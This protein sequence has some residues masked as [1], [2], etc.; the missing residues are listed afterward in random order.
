MRR[1]ANMIPTANEPGYDTWPPGSHE[2]GGA[3]PWITGSWDPELKMYFT[4]TANAYEWN[5]KNRGGGKMDNLGAAGIVA[6]NT[7]T[8]KTEWRYTA[9]P[10]DPRDVRTPQPPMLITI[11]GRNTVRH[12]TQHR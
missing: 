12:P 4:G 9:V 5:P 3:G 6:V 7:E 2:H 11:D 1:K 10:G 8:G